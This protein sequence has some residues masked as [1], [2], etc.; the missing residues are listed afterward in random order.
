M[1]TL[2]AIAKVVLTILV[3]VSLAALCSESDNFT[4]QFIWTYSWLLVMGISG[5]TLCKL[6][7]DEDDEQEV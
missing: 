6:L 5:W 7:N 4:Y 3:W 2:K 1:K